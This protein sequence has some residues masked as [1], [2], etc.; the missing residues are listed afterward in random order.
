MPEQGSRR[1]HGRARTG[2]GPS[3]TTRWVAAALAGLAA[4]LALMPSAA[5]AEPAPAQLNAADQAL[6]DGV[7]QAGLWEMPAGQMAAEKGKRQRV[8]E[9]GA[10]IAKQH[11][12]LDQMV[13]D[14]ANKLGVRIPPTPRPD[15][16]GWLT[17]MQK[18]EGDRFDQTFVTRLRTAHG[19][20]FPVI[21]AVRASTRNEDVRKLADAANIFVM[22]HMKML[23]S[24]GLVRYAE[25][26]PPAVP[27]MQNEG[28]F[29]RARANAGSGAPVNSTMIWVVLVVALAAGGVATVRL[30]RR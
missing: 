4:G 9:V 11:V 19:K 15:Q 29:A 28:M 16:Q 5:S 26:P 3:R 14:T 21:G 18:A 22:N 24:T 8:R 7:R 2:T 30:I 27:A 20:I 6:L 17:E 1:T 10:E 13:V 23:E 12:Q 25:L